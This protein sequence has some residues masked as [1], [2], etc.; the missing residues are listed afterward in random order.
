MYPLQIRIDVTSDIK[1]N[2]LEIFRQ[3][4]ERYP[5]VLIGFEDP[6]PKGTNLHLH[7]FVL[8]NDENLKNRKQNARN[9]IKKNLILP[10]GNG[11]YSISKTYTEEFSKIGVYA[12]KDGTFIYY[13]FTQDEID[14]YCK[15][16]FRKEDKTASYKE[17]LKE[18]NVKW[19]SNEIESYEMYITKF[20]ELRIKY[21]KPISRNQAETYFEH[22]MMKKSP[23]YLQAVIKW[24]AT[25]LGYKF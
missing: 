23:K 13:G 24:H 19:F 1:E 20:Y 3:N 22:Q 17:E 2:V 4:I 11:S 12:V 8:S 7:C 16:S 15:R 14:E 5:K 21:D 18:L 10:N 6:D 9:L 25:N